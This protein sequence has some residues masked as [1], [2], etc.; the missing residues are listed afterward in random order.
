M[1]LRIPNLTQIVWQNYLRSKA[2]I[3][4][5]NMKKE[6]L[7]Y[8]RLCLD[9]VRVSDKERNGPSGLDVHLDGFIW[10]ECNGLFS[11]LKPHFLCQNWKVRNGSTW[12][13]IIK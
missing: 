4:I 1:Q 11:H 13:N 6:I 2:Q 8:L 12:L 7:Q 3:T 5:L 9:R 10:M